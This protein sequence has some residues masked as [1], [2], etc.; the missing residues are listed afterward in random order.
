MNRSSAGWSQPL[1]FTVFLCTILISCYTYINVEIVNV[2]Q[3]GPRYWVMGKAISVQTNVS[4]AWT[5]QWTDCFLIFRLK[6]ILCDCYWCTYSCGMFVDFCWCRINWTV[7]LKINGNLNK[8]QCDLW[9]ILWIIKRKGFKDVCSIFCS[10][11]F[12]PRNVWK[13]SIKDSHYHHLSS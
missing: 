5:W 12:I 8:N 3:M 9:W 2:N 7:V 6:F 13:K 11:K 1:A 4:A 10:A